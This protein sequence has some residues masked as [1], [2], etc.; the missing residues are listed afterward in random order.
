MIL[1]QEKIF[2][3]LTLV[4]LV[5]CL[6]FQLA[7]QAQVLEDDILQT[8]KNLTLNS[9]ALSKTVDYLL[10]DTTNNS[11]QNFTLDKTG[12]ILRVVPTKGMIN[13]STK[14]RILS[15]SGIEEIVY[16][17]IDGSVF[18]LVDPDK[19][20]SLIQESIINCET[21]TRHFDFAGEPVIC[22]ESFSVR[23]KENIMVLE[24]QTIEVN[25]L[26]LNAI[27]RLMLTLPDNLEPF[28]PE[29]FDFVQ[30]TSPDDLVVARTNS[31]NYYQAI[32]Q[33]ESLLNI[34]KFINVGNFCVSSVSD[35][36]L[37]KKT[38]DCSF[39]SP[40]V[41]SILNF[42]NAELV[43]GIKSVNIV[44]PLIP[45]MFNT[46]F[47]ELVFTVNKETKPKTSPTQISPNSLQQYFFES[48]S[49]DFST[50]LSEISKEKS[51]TSK[52]IFE[53]TKS[54][55]L[56]QKMNRISFLVPLSKI[57]GAFFLPDVDKKVQMF[58]DNLSL[59]TLDKD[60]NSRLN[61]SVNNN[62]VIN[63]LF[64]E[65]KERVVRS[66]VAD[67]ENLLIETYFPNESPQFSLNRDYVFV[68]VNFT[69][70]T[71]AN[72]E[73]V[74]ILSNK[75]KLDLRFSTQ[76][77]SK[78]SLIQD[79]NPI[80]LRSSENLLDK[81]DVFEKLGGLSGLLLAPDSRPFLEPG[82]RNAIELSMVVDLGGSDTLSLD[83]SD[84]KTKDERQEFNI[85]N[86]SFV[87][88]GKYEIKIKFDSDREKLF[89]N[90]G[91]VKGSND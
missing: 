45:K 77:L 86:F 22:P 16:S 74:D 89:Q 8:I 66:Q 37:A 52:N 54:V 1:W 32:T 7:V 19:T 35:R 33:D 73:P 90:A 39:S 57:P 50:L 36:N 64:D 9:R 30:V 79:V 76:F 53:L 27:Y 61:L 71:G 51:K 88:F 62:I 44:F 21:L 6:L 4:I 26:K 69:K 13:N 81:N 70:G 3:G 25:F 11:S 91:L 29:I 84:L 67:N 55:S 75:S 31:N 78:D 15:D 68:E 42:E 60:A 20:Y 34:A 12:F 46:L 65:Q 14:V 59:L 10:D 56:E 87:P 58:L 63:D 83:Y 82:Y 48:Y 85:Y 41:K 43:S 2:R 18:A 38:N 49:S 24:D 72:G 17:A 28:D 47:H 40:K 5:N 23:L 80:S